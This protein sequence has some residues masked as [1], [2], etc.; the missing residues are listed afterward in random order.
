MINSKIIVDAGAD[1]V[2]IGSALVDLIKS[3]LNNHS[4]ME[5]EMVEFVSSIKNR[6]LNY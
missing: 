2:I 6:L 5:I 1:G 3:N 4:K